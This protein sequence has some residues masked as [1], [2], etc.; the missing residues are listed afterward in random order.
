MAGA[1]RVVPVI[2][3]ASCCVFAQTSDI[4]TELP[5]VTSSAH[6][7]P[8]IP[9]DN[10]GASVDIL[11]IPLLKEEGVYSLSDAVATAPGVFTLPGGGINQRGNSSNIAIRGLSSAAYTLCT[12]DGMRLSGN[13]GSGGGNVA[14]NV[15]ART[16]LHDIGN[17]EILKGSQG[18]L[19]GGGAIGGVV[20]LETPKGEG[21]PSVSLF[22]EAGSFGSYTGNI[23]SQGQKEALSW[24][25][26]A[27]YEH[28]DNDLHTA[29]GIK[30]TSP[31]AGQYQNWSEAL[32]L[33]YELNEA[34]TLTL[35]YR[36]EDGSY[37]YA[38]ITPYG[39]TAQLYTFRSNL[40]TAKLQSKINERFTT[41]IMA[42]YY[43]SDIMYGRGDT[44]HDIR[45]VQVEWRNLYRWCRHQSTTAGFSW[46]RD[47]FTNDSVWAPGSNT[48][49]NLQNT[50]G[51]FAEHHIAPTRHWD[52]SLALRLDHSNNFHHLWTARAASSYR[53][54]EERTRLF[55]SVGLGYRAPNSFQSTEGASYSNSSGTYYGNSNLDCERSRSADIG[56]EHE[57]VR[58]HSLSVSFFWMR[59][60]D[61]ITAS[62]LG[63]GAYR[64]EN[65]NS[66][67]TAQGVEL[68][69]KGSFTDAWDT[70]YSLSCTLVQPKTS[71]DLQIANSARQ[72]WAADIH[73]SPL[74]GLTT[75]IGLTAVNGRSDYTNGSHL[76][77][78]YTLRWY[79]QYEVNEHLTLH[80]RVEN[81]TNQRFIT[82]QSWY[83]AEYSLINPGTAV[84]GGCTI[85]F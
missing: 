81:L 53:F 20:W 25:V 72:I 55:G 68:C 22:N 77:A 23:T 5:P 47:D 84:Y 80:L 60:E 30:P 2:T 36:R 29:S 26:S 70:G 16:T 54:N 79:A 83:G 35:T 58:N 63:N 6:A 67:Q 38:D 56:V 39:E 11:D 78:Y 51:I 59:T 32:R 8:E 21:E 4:V 73:T 1:S 3:L 71:D 85:T 66:H 43:G 33:D 48:D 15:L 74:E 44:Y 62:P 75:G 46:N 69:L 37:H 10:T 40:L 18:A 50:Y 41:S 76:D 82:S 61:A 13:A 64:Y 57:F 27:T 19:Y 49:R 65:S 52:N 17:V 45:N 42:G 12:M 34:N 28:T 24:F 14:P 7:G 31:N 9:Y